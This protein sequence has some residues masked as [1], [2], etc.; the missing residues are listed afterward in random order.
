MR[1]VAIGLLVAFALGCGA[2]A[3]G[4]L[5]NGTSSFPV[6]LYLATGK[7]AHKGDLVLVSLPA[8]PVFEMARSRGYLNVAYS[9]TPHILKRMVGV[10]GDRITIDSAGVEVNGIRLENSAPLPCD[11]GGRR[12]IP[13]IVRNYVLGPGE[14]LLMSDYNPASFDSRYFG[15]LQATAIESVVRPLLTR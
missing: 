5:Y 14:V 3:L 15:P 8:L 4:V 10:S 13:Y 9:P 6:G 7:D 2:L 11:G 1:R 12:L